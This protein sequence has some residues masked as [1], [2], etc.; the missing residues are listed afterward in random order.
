MSFEQS[1]GQEKSA[2]KKVINLT[3]KSDAN[4]SA[5]MQN[6]KKNPGK[7]RANSTD[8]SMRNDGR[9]EAPK[10]KN[11]RPRGQHNRAQQQNKK[12]QNDSWD[13]EKDQ[14]FDLPSAPIK[15]SASSLDEVA[16]PGF[17]KPQEKKQRE[18]KTNDGNDTASLFNNPAPLQRAPSNE[19]NS[20]PT[21]RKSA[22]SQPDLYENSAPTFETYRNKLSAV[23]VDTLLNDMKFTKMTPVQ[24]HT[25]VPL[26]NNR[27]CHVQAKTGTGKT[28]SFLVPSIQKILVKSKRSGISLLVISPTR[29]LAMQI[30]TEAKAIT[31][32]IPGIKIGISIGGTNI[33]S[34]KNAI[35]SGLDILIATPGRLLDHLSDAKISSQVYYLDTFVL[36]ECD[37]LLDMGF[38]PDIFKILKHLPT[39]NRQSILCSATVTPRVKEIASKLLKQDHDF[40]ST[41]PKGDVD[42]HQKVPQFMVQSPFTEQLLMTIT[43]LQLEASPK[44]KAIV[45]LPTAHLAN[46][47]YATYAASFPRNTFVQHSR[48]SQSKRQKVSDDYKDC[49]SGILFATVSCD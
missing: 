2:P 15:S 21:K 34:E 26:L 29:E 9:Q 3:L 23:I 27:D 28:V 22:P 39:E 48:Q 12:Q 7:D 37:R 5:Q 17:R 25:I 19:N 46:L 43:L 45:F 35:M 31:Q 47:Y 42:T 10:S 24:A 18:R 6:V 40:V 32:H 36:D 41:V 30:A 44:L 20:Q 4:W 49:S 38:S 14:A 13:S 1:T 8:I 11:Q 16:R 33:N